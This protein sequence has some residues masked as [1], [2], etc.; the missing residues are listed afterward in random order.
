MIVRNGFEESLAGLKKSHQQAQ[1]EENDFSG[2]N[3]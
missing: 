2:E 3:K 1:T